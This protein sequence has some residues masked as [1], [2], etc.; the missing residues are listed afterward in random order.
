MKPVD[1]STLPIRLR[2]IRM[3]SSFIALSCF[4]ISMTRS[5]LMNLLR[6]LGGSVGIA[7]IGFL[8]DRKVY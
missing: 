4:T 2:L 3:G 7:L 5:E 6:Q 8:L 1:A